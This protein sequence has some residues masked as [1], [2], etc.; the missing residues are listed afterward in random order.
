MTRGCVNGVCMNPGGP[1]PPGG[2]GEASCC[3]QTGPLIGSGICS[4]AYHYGLPSPDCQPYNPDPADGLIDV[5]CQT[6]HA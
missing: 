3:I 5:P 4:Q 2:P 1:T 6:V